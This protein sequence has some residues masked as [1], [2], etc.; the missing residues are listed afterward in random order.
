MPKVKSKLFN[1]IQNPLA[2]RGHGEASKS[3]LSIAFYTHGN[4]IIMRTK[5]KSPPHTSAAQ[6]EQHVLWSDA[7]CMYRGMTWGQRVLFNNYY[8]REREAGRTIY[9]GRTKLDEA[10]QQIPQLD[11]GRVAYFM[12]HALRLDL[13]NY[14][15]NFLKSSWLI[16]SLH[17]TG[18]SW[19]LTAGLTNPAEL[20]EAV[21]F[22]EKLP[23]RSGR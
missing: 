9:T 11:M 14:L 8:V 18:T 23:V 3:G 16:V 12:S 7:D 21:I 15:E 5:P 6:R 19:E 17:D 1:A 4:D 20:T 2:G 13:L 10:G 22:Q